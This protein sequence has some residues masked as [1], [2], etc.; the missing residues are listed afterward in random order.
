MFDSLQY[1]NNKL[2]NSEK[3]LSNLKRTIK[4]ITFTVLS[5]T[6]TISI[7]NI[8]DNNQLNIN[9]DSK[10]THIVK[11]WETFY[12]IA[13]RIYWMSYKK[14]AKINEKNIPVPADIKKWD[15]IYLRYDFKKENIIN[16]IHLSKK[17]LNIAKSI[18]SE[19]DGWKYIIHKELDNINLIDIVPKWI[20]IVKIQNKDTIFYTSIDETT[21]TFYPDFNFTKT[22]NQNSLKWTVITFYTKNDLKNWILDNNSNSKTKILNLSEYFE[23]FSKLNYKLDI[24]DYKDKTLWIYKIAKEVESETNAWK[25]IINEDA[26]NIQ[27]NN[28]VPKD[29]NLVKVQNLNWFYYIARD[30]LGNYLDKT[31]LWWDILTFYTVEDKQKWRYW[32]DEIRYPKMT[33]KERFEEYSEAWKDWYRTIKIKSDIVDIIKWVDILDKNKESFLLSFEWFINELV[34][35]NEKW[36]FVFDNQYINKIPPLT[37]NIKFKP[38]T[39]ADLVSYKEEKQETLKFS[40]NYWKNIYRHY[41]N[42]R[43]IYREFKDENWVPIC[44][45]K[46][47]PLLEKGL[48]IDVPNS[49][50]D[51]YKYELFLDSLVG[52]YFD[53]VYVWTPDKSPAWSINVYRKWYWNNIFRQNGGHVENV[54]EDESWKKWYY[55]WGLS[56]NPSWSTYANKLDNSKTWFTWFA[57]LPKAKFNQT[58]WPSNFFKNWSKNIILTSNSVENNAEIVFSRVMN[59]IKKKEI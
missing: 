6:S 53:K 17:L 41:L 55:Y 52:I 32:T 45:W 49:N 11:Q 26:S 15:I 18:K 16:N 31:V 46:F 7:A 38:L 48:W 58:K 5:T 1:I 57:Y 59:T 22:E 10:W 20:K 2:D 39:K 29:I 27:L 25:Y 50:M 8:T 3:I 47:R 40:I 9:N 14:L 4:A 44:W 33:K 28:I 34:I 24:N 19:N 54:T 23:S 43:K 51:W 12:W 37:N 21:N 42:I 36:E 35:K 56:S 30:K 13:T